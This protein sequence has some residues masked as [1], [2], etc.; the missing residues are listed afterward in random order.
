MFIF[1]IYMDDRSFCNLRWQRHLMTGLSTTMVNETPQPLIFEKPSTGLI[2]ANMSL[3]YKIYTHDLFLF[4]L[5]DC[6]FYIIFFTFVQESQVLNFKYFLKRSH[7]DY[8]INDS[9]ISIMETY[10]ILYH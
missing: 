2:Y 8:S 7:S 9:N 5:Q 4:L 10:P 3:I 1:M 6:L